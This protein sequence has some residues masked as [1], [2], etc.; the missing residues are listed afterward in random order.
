MLSSLI[1]YADITNMSINL[2]NDHSSN[3]SRM[4]INKTLK[5]LI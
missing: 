3:F 5:T 1:K 2:I 4:I